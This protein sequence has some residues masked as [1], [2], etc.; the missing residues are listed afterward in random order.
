MI[1]GQMEVFGTLLLESR[2]LGGGVDY[3]E[4]RCLGR[5]CLIRGAG[6]SFKTPQKFL[7]ASSHLTGR[8]YTGFKAWSDLGSGQ[9][10]VYWVI[11]S[12]I[13]VVILTLT[14]LTA[15]TMST[16]LIHFLYTILANRY[17]VCIWGVQV[18]TH[19][20][21]HTIIIRAETKTLGWEGVKP[22]TWFFGSSNQN[23][24]SSLD[25]GCRI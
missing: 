7:Q 1:C 19:G 3:E 14:Q 11:D 15:Q 17:K 20:N 22:C 8:L 24:S 12:C 6:C 4:K 2:I 25:I 5:Y 9:S 23:S 16:K 18:Q 13:T 21:V 10:S